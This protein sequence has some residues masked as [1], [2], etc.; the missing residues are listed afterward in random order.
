MIEFNYSGKANRLSLIL[1]EKVRGITYGAIQKLFRKGD[2]RVNGKKVFKDTVVAD[3]DVIRV[4]YKEQERD[5]TPFIDNEYIACFF[6]PA[7]IACTGENSL[8]EAVK[9]KYGYIICHRLDTNTEG[10]VIFAKTEEV[11]AEMKK[12]FKT[13]SVEKH[14]LTAVAGIVRG[15]GELKAYLIKNA[16]ESFVKIYDKRMPG[17]VEIVTRY[18]AIYTARSGSVLDVELVTGRT[19]QIR[20]H[21]AHTG[22]PVI[23][24]PKYCPEKTNRYFGKKYQLL[25][26]YKVIFHIA[27][28]AL[29]A[30]D[31][32][33]I[34]YDSYDYLE[35]LKLIT[36]K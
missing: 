4:Y 34:E 5:F 9:T 18:D 19:H 22:H 21:L 7:R 12:L 6:K 20:A 26:A 11:F 15:S 16:D 17:S 33:K 25:R 13:R 30:L 2:V 8:E 31:G 36:E 28:G 24:D 35:N 23:G 32:V 10:I 27:D 14:Y 3:G 29:A 1:G